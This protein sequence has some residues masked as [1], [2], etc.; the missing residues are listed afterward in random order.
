MQKLRFY[1][2]LR[3][4]LMETQQLK[5]AAE[6]TFMRSQINLKTLTLYR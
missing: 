5:I 2:F 6:I 1:L 4:F 3:T